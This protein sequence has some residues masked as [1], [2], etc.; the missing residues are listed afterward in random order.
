MADWFLQEVKVID[1]L[2]K[3]E[4]KKDIDRYLVLN[5]GKFWLRAN[6]YN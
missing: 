4:N 5:Y 3:H 1:F 2:T 6:A